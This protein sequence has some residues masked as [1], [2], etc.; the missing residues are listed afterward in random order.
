[1]EARDVERETV[2]SGDVGALQTPRHRAGVDP[3]RVTGVDVNASVGLFFSTPSR[4]TPAW[5]C[6]HR[7]IHRGRARRVRLKPRAAVTS[8]G[9]KSNG[10][11]YESTRF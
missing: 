9:E 3:P 10:S 4:R 7:R 2:G 11:R 5:P 6:G 1:L 8:S